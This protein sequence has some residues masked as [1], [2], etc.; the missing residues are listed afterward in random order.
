MKI[1]QNRKA[2]DRRMTAAPIGVRSLL[3]MAGCTFAVIGMSLAAPSA[4]GAS[5]VNTYDLNTAQCSGTGCGEVQGFNFGTVTTNL[6]DTKTVLTYTFDLTTGLFH[7]Q[8]GS[9]IQATAAFDV[10]GTGISF[11]ETSNNSTGTWTDV[12][13]SVKMDGGGTWA[14]GVACSVSGN[15]CGNQLVVTFTGTNLAVASISGFGAAID[16][17]NSG[18]TG[19]IDAVLENQTGNGPPPAELPIPGAVWLFGSVL[20]GAG[21]LKKWRKRRDG[22]SQNSLPA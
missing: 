16:I 21:G 9:G 1:L 18:N 17:S 14:Q 8:A 11:S 12:T 22:A 4:A 6:N 2:L 5:T 3:S 7:E 19:V 15:T 13:G 20:A 10:T